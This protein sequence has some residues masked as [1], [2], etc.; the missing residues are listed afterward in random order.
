MKEKKTNCGIYKIINLI[1]D[2]KTGI[3]KVYIGS[4]CN[5]KDR[6][7][8][9]TGMLRKGIHVNNHLQFAV[10]KYEIENFKFDI[11]KYVEK[12]EDKQKLKEE[13][14]KWE[15]HYLN[16]YVVNG[17]V[18]SNRCYN[19]C[20]TAGSRLGMPPTFKGRKHSEESKKKVSES[21]KGEKNGMYGKVGILSPNYERVKSAEEREK[22]SRGNKGK[23]HSDETKK[24]LKELSTGRLHTEET[25]KKLS[26]LRIQ[27]NENPNRQWTDDSRKNLSDAMK[28]RIFT[29]EWKEKIR[30]S[31]LNP[32]EE[33]KNIVRES[34]SKKIINLTT[35]KIFNSAVEAAKFYGISDKHIGTVCNGKRKSTGGYEWAHCKGE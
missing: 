26:I 11:V 19:I 7:Y 31:K 3:H 4:S 10:K 25:K 35:G 24:I 30:V 12:I 28:G 33:W 9:H 15:Q 20:I 6:K 34:N 2:E 27:D 5:L 13:L 21:N 16:D 22:I 32:S 1:P 14:L 17:K 8:R 29:D 23:K 18:D